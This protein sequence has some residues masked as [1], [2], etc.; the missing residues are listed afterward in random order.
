VKQLQKARKKELKAISHEQKKR[1]VSA[2]I[3]PERLAVA[4]APLGVSEAPLVPEKA[5]FQWLESLV[6]HSQRPTHRVGKLGFLGFVGLGQ[7]VDTIDYC[8]V[9]MTG[10]FGDTQY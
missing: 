9:R 10:R 1:R 7:K 2:D 8:K 3:D 4:P 6:P 5:S